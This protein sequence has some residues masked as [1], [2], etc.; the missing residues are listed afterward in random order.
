MERC[1]HTAVPCVCR[2]Q[3][4][5]VSVGTVTSCSGVRSSLAPHKLRLTKNLDLSCF[6]ESAAFFAKILQAR[7]RQGAFAERGA[8]HTE[9]SG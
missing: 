9:S 6:L 8:V 5:L 7:Q 4:K 2:S 3:E 1:G